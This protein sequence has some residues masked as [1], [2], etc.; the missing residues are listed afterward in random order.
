MFEFLKNMWIMRN[1]D[2]AYLTDKVA[3]GRIT[4]EQK[5]EI[6]ATEQMASD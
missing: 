3:K 5:V 2:E 6:L 4:E 1:I